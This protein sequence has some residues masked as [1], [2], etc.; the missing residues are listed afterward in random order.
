VSLE[1]VEVV[2][3]VEHVRHARI[4]MRPSVTPLM[5]GY[6]GLIQLPIFEGF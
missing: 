2:A 1:N 3:L 4:I 5:D 6:N